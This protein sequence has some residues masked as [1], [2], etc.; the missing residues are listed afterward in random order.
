MNLKWLNP[1]DEYLLTTRLRIEEVLRLLDKWILPKSTYE[2]FHFPIPQRYLLVGKIEGRVFEGEIEPN[3][4]SYT[5]FRGQIA[6]AGA[7]TTITIHAR[8]L[9]KGRWFFYAAIVVSVV[10]AILFCASIFLPF[11]PNIADWKPGI[12]LALLMGILSCIMIPVTYN[13]ERNKF[14]NMLVTILAATVEKRT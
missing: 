3:R 6:E 5:H 2:F 13:M 14:T 4:K 7:I 1:Q 11:L 10:S 9:H 8:L 12:L